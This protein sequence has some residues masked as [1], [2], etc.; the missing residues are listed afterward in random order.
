MDL[1]GQLQVGTS[2]RPRGRRAS[3]PP[4]AAAVRISIGSPKA[5]VWPDPVSARPRTSRPASPSGRVW[6]WMGR[7]VVMPRAVSAA[8]KAEGTP[9]SAKELAVSCGLTARLEEVAGKWERHPFGVGRAP[10][11]PDGARTSAPEAGVGTNEVR[12]L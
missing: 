10:Q 3:R 4:P 2:T 7:G 11:V 8:V 9:S 1:V 5:S 6:A 12:G